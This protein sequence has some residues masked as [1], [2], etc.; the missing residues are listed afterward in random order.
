MIH[1]N[2]LLCISDQWMVRKNAKYHHILVHFGNSLA[3][4]GDKVGF[5]TDDLKNPLVLRCS[6][7]QPVFRLSPYYQPEEIPRGNS[8]KGIFLDSH[9]AETEMFLTRNYRWDFGRD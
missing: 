1:T 3:D 9:L 7:F 6:G 5:S 4:R 8:F 2:R